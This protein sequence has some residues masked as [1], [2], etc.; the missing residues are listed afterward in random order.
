MS[1]KREYRN[2]RVLFGV[3]VSK[4]GDKSIGVLVQRLKQHRRYKKYIRVSKKF[5][6]HDERNEA[7]IGDKVMIV[8]SRPLSATKR[9]R[10]SKIVEKSVERREAEQ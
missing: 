10:L 8:E 9:W 2:K 3:V 1:E 6:A 4:V 7:Q 5:I